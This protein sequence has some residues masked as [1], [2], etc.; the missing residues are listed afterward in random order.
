M[1]N[2]DRPSLTSKVRVVSTEKR[3][4]A[5]PLAGCAIDAVLKIPGS[6]SVTNRALILAALADGTS[7]LIGPLQSRDTWLMAAGLRSIGVEIE[8]VGSDWK[9]TR[10]K[11]RGPATIDV[12]NAGT[13]MRFLPPV[14]AL[15]TGAIRFDGDPRSHE[16]P[17]GPVI[18]GL[19]TIGATVND[20]GRNAI[21]LTVEGHGSLRGG[22]VSID[23]SASSQFVSA[24]LLVAPATHD[25]ITVRHIGASLPSTPHINMTVQ[26]LRKFGAIVDDSEVHVW[27]V[28]SGPLLPQRMVIEPDL[29]NAAPF[30]GAALVTG[31]SVTIRDWPT[32]TAQPG[33]ELRNLLAMMGAD[34]E[35]VPEGLRV[36]AGETLVGIDFDLHEVGELT[37]VIAAICALASTKSLLRGIGHLRL[38]ETDRLTA[39]ATEINRLGGKVIEGPDS[40]EIHPQRLHGGLFHTYDDHRIATAGALIGLIVPGVEIENIETTQKTIPDFV[41]LWST[42]LEA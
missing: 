36:S 30:L 39:L 37:P 18:S 32:S 15:A 24:M 25:G 21:P 42:M 31:G 14:A 4:W 38:H 17:I 41:G 9:I 11:L 20:D 8:D 3:D 6:K 7:N 12:G 23:A 13:V 22:E 34:V 19:R 35:F 5:A 2:G 33:D 27:R 40:L 29:S 1:V 10:G 28:E 16:R 26:M